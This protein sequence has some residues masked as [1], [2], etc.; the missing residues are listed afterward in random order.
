MKKLIT[1]ILLFMAIGVKAQSNTGYFSS[2]NAATKNGTDTVVNTQSKVQSLVLP[3][4][5]DILTIQV[6]VS[7]ISGTVGGTL[8]L[9][10]SIDNDNTVPIGSP[11]T[12]INASN[13]YSFHVN[14]SLYPYYFIKLNGTGTMN[15]SFKSFWLARKVI[16]QKQQ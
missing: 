7:K 4:Y 11:D 3:G 14:P 9:Y 16:V 15:A 1:I 2:A 5:W 13:V 10:G 12:V 8:Q 6:N